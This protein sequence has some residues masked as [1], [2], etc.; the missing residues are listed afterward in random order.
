MKRT[1]R[2]AALLCALSI[3]A[4]P[5]R[6]AGQRYTDVAGDEWFAPAAEE[7]AQQGIMTGVD[8]S[9][10]AP[11]VSVTRATAVTVLWRLSGEPESGA[12]A[13]TDTAGTWYETAAAWA[14]GA[15]IAT[16]YADGSF[17]GDD[18]VT[19]EQLAAFF[20]RYAALRGEQLAEGNLALF[21]DGSSVSDWAVDAMRH[22]VGAGILQGSDTGYL[23]PQGTANRAALATMLQRMLIPAA[24]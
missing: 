22:A 15:G 10:F 23:S 1:I 14:R 4:L 24:G 7:L 18:K 20:Y 11:Y 9:S 6:A 12:A 5:A 17:G 8:E 3:F 16:G 2:C 19:R 21:R 13:F